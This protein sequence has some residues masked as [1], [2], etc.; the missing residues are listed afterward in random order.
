MSSKKTNLSDYAPLNLEG[1]EQWKIGIITAD[2]NPEITHSLRDACKA[3]LEAEGIPGEQLFL[4]SVPGTF[5][6]P[7]AAKILLQKH[8]DI[9]AVIAIGCV[10]KGETTH[11]EYINHAVATGLTQLS[12]LSGKPC[13]FGVLTP[14]TMEQAKDRAGGKHGN[15]GIEAAVTAL[16]MIDL[17]KNMTSD[18]PSIGF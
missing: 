11:N 7:V 5:E 14:N 4:S 1:C 16:R 9:D 3:T 2:W 12:I 18:Q 8:G 13:I 6:L 17:K 10:I 15:K